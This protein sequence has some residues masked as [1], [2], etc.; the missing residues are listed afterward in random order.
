MTP[1][2]ALLQQTDVE[3]FDTIF[4]QLLECGKVSLQ[5]QLYQKCKKS[6]FFNYQLRPTLLK[7]AQ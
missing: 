2:L 6:F 4:M 7:E 1:S 3:V 5:Y